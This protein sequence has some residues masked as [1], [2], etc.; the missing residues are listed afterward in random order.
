M[1]T[2]IQSNQAYQNQNVDVPA[3][4][5]DTKI[6]ALSSSAIQQST[7]C[8]RFW[9]IARIIVGI[10]IMVIGFLAL[11]GLA[12]V[13]IAGRPLP[14]IGPIM[15]AVANKIG[16][17]PAW[18]ASAVAF[19]SPGIIGAIYIALKTNAEEARRKKNAKAAAENQQ[20]IA[21]NPTTSLIKDSSP[22]P[23]NSSTTLHPGRTH[24]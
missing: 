11:N 5:K 24:R 6:T 4:Q 14:P 3:K 1:V 20:A 18:I 15:L 19:V 17:I 8:C 21:A 7:R 13:Y 10:A 9:E 2:S 16:V 12:S 23:S 22:Q